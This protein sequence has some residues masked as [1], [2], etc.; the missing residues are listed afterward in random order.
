MTYPTDL[1]NLI[2]GGANPQQLVM[3]VLED[4]M[5]GTPIGDNI[6]TLAKDNR[7]DEIEKFARN[8]CAQNGIDFDKEFNAFRK[9]LGL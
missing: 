2:K 5:A 9:N 7:T 1:I 6:I 3:K 8:I 4:R